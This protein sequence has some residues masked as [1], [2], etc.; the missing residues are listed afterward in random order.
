MATIRSLAIAL[1]T[2]LFVPS[3]S[4]SQ[5]GRYSSA[6][7]EQLK[8]DVRAMLDEA[9]VPG[10]FDRAGHGRL[11]S[12]GRRIG[13]SRRAAGAQSI[14]HLNQ[15]DDDALDLTAAKGVAIIPTIAFYR[16][17]YRENKISR[18]MIERRGWKREV[19]ETLFR[20]A[21][22]RG[23]MLGVGLDAVFDMM[24]LYP[25][26]YFEEM[27][28]FVELGMT[29][30]EAIVAATRPSGVVQRTGQAGTGDDR[31]TDPPG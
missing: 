30:M 13:Q 5:S 2:L 20:K 28:Y 11:G 21:H 14:E 29:P 8:K 15:M 22:Q 1:T 17:L 24:K 26:R 10:R 16:H 31:R 27:R 25:D 12:L 9:R 23:I 6:D 18:E 3:S 7:L 4:L 19:H